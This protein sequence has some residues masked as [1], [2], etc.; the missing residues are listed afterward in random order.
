MSEAPSAASFLLVWCVV[1]HVLVS[2]DRR[3]VAFFFSVVSLPC[4]LRYWV[5]GAFLGDA[6]S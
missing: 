4:P 2:M 1:S 3:Q 6:A 5:C